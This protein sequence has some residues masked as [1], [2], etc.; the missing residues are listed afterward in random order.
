MR[1]DINTT[2]WESLQNDNINMHAQNI[3]DRIISAS[4]KYIPNKFV[5][6]RCTDPPWLNFNIRKLI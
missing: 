5:T 1:N 6:I 2:N 3:S 4:E